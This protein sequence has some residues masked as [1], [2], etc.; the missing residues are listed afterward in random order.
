MIKIFALLVAAT[1][2]LGAA[3]GNV[4]TVDVT[5]DRVENLVDVLNGFDKEENN[6][7]VIVVRGDIKLEIT[8]VQSA[9]GDRRFLV[10]DYVSP[11]DS[12]TYRA[13]VDVRDV[14]LVEERPK[15][16]TPAF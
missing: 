5:E 1:L 12:R 4:E 2:G 3:R 15:E 8:N 10:I 13:A 11:A 7:V 16:N 6:V 14:L 9:H